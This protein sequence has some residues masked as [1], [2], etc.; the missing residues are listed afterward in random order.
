MHFLLDF[1]WF[2]LALHPEGEQVPCFGVVA[3][4][5]GPMYLRLEL[6]VDV[7]LCVNSACE[8]NFFTCV[9]LFHI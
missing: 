7:A 1:L 5:Y 3:A 6:K 4:T 2:S 9:L 8:T